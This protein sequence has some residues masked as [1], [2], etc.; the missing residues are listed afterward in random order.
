MTYIGHK[1]FLSYRGGDYKTAHDL[2]QDLLNQGNCKQIVLVPPEKISKSNEILLPFEFFELM[3]FITDN[4]YDCDAFIILDTEHYLGSYWTQ[5]EVRQ[6]RRFAKQPEAYIARPAGQHQAS[7]REKIAL[8]PLDNGDAKLRARVSVGTNRRM[9]QSSG[10][11]AAWGKFA[12]NCFL[13]P[14]AYCGRHF[15]ATQKAVYASLNKNFTVT[16]SS[17]RRQIKVYRRSPDG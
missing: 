7:I 6:W 2:A 8:D 10:I 9:L 14:C 16:V 3:E 11:P 12:K 17:L 4:L 1:V 5:M 13:V 15:L